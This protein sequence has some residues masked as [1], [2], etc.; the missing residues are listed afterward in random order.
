M[1][2][3]SP[4][5]PENAMG[6]HAPH[7]L[8]AIDEATGV[9]REIITALTGNLTGAH[10]QIVMICNP[11][12]RDTYAFEAER[13]G[14]WKV[15]EISAFD[16]PNVK[17]ETETIHGAVTREWIVDR[18]RSWSEEVRANILEASKTV[19]VWWLNTWFRRNPLVDARILG[20]WAQLES[21]GFIP[22]ELIRAHIPSR[23]GVPRSEWDAIPTLPQGTP[24]VRALGI[25]ISRG[26]GK[27][28][29]VYSKFE[30]VP[31]AP[32]IQRLFQSFFDEDLMA[33]ADRIRNEYEQCAR[34]GIELVIALDD[35]GLG[36][37]VSDRLKQ[38]GVPHFAVNA[39]HKPKGFFA[40]KIMANARA[41][42]Y[43]LL[44]SEL[45]EGKI[46]LQDYGRFHAELSAIRLDV[47]KTNGT[48]KMEDKSLTK[49]RL[50]R[51]PDFADATALAR[52]GLRLRQA[53]KNTKFF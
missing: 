32:D 49:Q 42:M 46:L 53:A 23:E 24:K 40:D 25:D 11:I 6:F 17:G 48:Y 18:L 45:Q 13:S 35:T 36:G 27:D 28:A 33:T 9:D 15:I 34:E 4:N 41:E 50:G 29:T 51:S 20:E 31:D 47:S 7:I 12:D 38:L 8:V 1:I 3:I 16:H 2:G 22:L 10:A 39:N 44:K 37:G 26:L 52:Y 14:Q 5:I 43:F 30:V 19:Y 21:A